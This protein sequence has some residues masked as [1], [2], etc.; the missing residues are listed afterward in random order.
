MDLRPA[1]RRGV[2]RSIFQTVGFDRAARV[3]GRRTS[4]R[5]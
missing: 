3:L 5:A 1:Q 2:T 4:G